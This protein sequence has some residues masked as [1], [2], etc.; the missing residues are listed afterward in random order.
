MRTAGVFSLIL[1]LY[2]AVASSSRFSPFYPPL[3][4]EPSLKW[5]DLLPLHEK[6]QGNCPSNYNACSN[7]NAPF[8]CCIAN[9]NCQLDAVGHVACCPRGSACTGTINVGTQVAS[10][11]SGSAIV[12]PPSTLTSSGGFILPGSTSAQP[13]VQPTG[14]GVITTPPPISNQYYI[15]PAIPTSFAS[16]AACSAAWSG[17]QNEYQKCTVQLGGRTDGITISASSAGITIPAATAT[18]AGINSVSI[19]QS[20]S[21]Q[22]CYGLQ[23]MNCPAYNGV[24]GAATMHCPGMYGIGVGLALG[25]AGQIIG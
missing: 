19:C 21:Q 11:T 3:V 13:S 2:S 25:V 7:L 1:A 5:R 12:V 15:F 24:P 17:C 10:T 18:G 16:A 22:A 9:T 14:I 23:I 4:E 8:A 6:R 20:M